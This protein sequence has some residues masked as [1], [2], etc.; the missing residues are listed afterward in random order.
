MKKILYIS[1]VIAGIISINSC[2]T[3]DLDLTNPNELAPDTYFTN[4]L[5]IQSAVNAAYSNLQTQGLYVRHSFFSLDNM[6]Q[7]NEGNSQLE[8]NKR[9]FLN[10]T[11]DSSSD[12]IETYWGSCYSGIA[13]ANFI[14]Q[15]QDKINAI[16]ESQLS[17]VRKNKFIAEARFL[18]AYYYFL[19]V[20]R[21]GDIPLY[22]K[23]ESVGKGRSPKADVYKLI[24][25][26]LDFASKNLLGKSTEDKG[27]A[28]KEAAF[29]YLGK[30]LLYEKK[31]DEALVAFNN[32][33]GF[34][35]E[36]NY[37]DNFTEENEHG[38][39][40]IF[41]IEFTAA[42]TTD[43]S[44]WGAATSGEGL[45]EHTFRGQEYG[46]LD[47]FNVYPSTQLLNSFEAGDKRY[48]GSFYSP[49]DSYSNG[50]KTM[51]AA[52]SNNRA[53]GWKK[54]QN[55]YHRDQENTDSGINFKVMRYADVLLMKAECLALKSAPDFPAA[56]ALITEVRSRAGL[57]T[58]I[59]ANKTAVFN[60]I[61]HERKVELAGEQVRFD[62]IIRWGIASTE[63]AGTGFT[64]GKN[65]LW[66]IPDREASSNSNIVGQQNPNY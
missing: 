54:Y 16:L 65:E 19:L 60:A 45:A 28:T 52:F 38:V 50:T 23:T 24:E 48:A 34:T 46:V 59:A 6:A 8:Q 27:R 2:D 63:L 41:E 39:E 21:F 31:Y 12:I 13:K 17:Q 3:R 22:D 25:E 51:P 26:D 53:A 7:D 29:A 35:L 30:V 9:L 57:T 44:R 64:A 43:A 47:W 15:N 62:D 14:I 10:F 32:V 20:C 55:Y 33:T 5:Q 37:F 36:P 61:V 49:G 40:S 42:Y 4:E 11:F 56:I 58:T 1:I 18:R 66:P